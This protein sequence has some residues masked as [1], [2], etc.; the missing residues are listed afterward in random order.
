[1]PV[2]LNWL[3]MLLLSHFYMQL[4]FKKIILVLKYLSNYDT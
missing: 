3:K 2:T 1:M 4:L